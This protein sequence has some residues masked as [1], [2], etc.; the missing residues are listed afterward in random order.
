MN[1]KSIIKGEKE[2]LEQFEERSI[3]VSHNYDNYVFVW[4]SKEDF[5]NPNSKPE[6]WDTD[7]A[8]RYVET[9][10]SDV[11]REKTKRR[12]WMLEQMDEDKGEQKWEK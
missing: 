3:W 5:H 1:L 4:K 6:K 9:L 10:E 8:R 11:E 2:S 7:K 12:V